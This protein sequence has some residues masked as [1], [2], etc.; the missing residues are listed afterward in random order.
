MTNFYS[1]FS[2]FELLLWRRL[3]IVPF[4]LRPTCRSFR[5]WFRFRLDQNI[6]LIHPPVTL[7]VT[8]TSDQQGVLLWNVQLP[9]S[10]RRLSI[11]QSR[12][13]D[14]DWNGNNVTNIF[15]FVYIFIFQSSGFIFYYFWP[16]NTGAPPGG[17]EEKWQENKEKLQEVRTKR[18]S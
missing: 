14:A 11:D 1:S 9:S 16:V 13:K 12:W 10:Y 3:A 5:I 7:C 4:T 8:F 17:R 15:P 6:L 2:F 18:G